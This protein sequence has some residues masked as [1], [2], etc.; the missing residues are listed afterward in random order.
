M[1]ITTWNILAQR[2]APNG[3]IQWKSRLETI[4]KVLI[5]LNSDII[6][7]Q[8]VELDCIHDLDNLLDYD[9]VGHVVSNQRTN[10]IGNITLWKREKLT[11]SQLFTNST[12]VLT[13]FTN[14]LCICNVHL[15]ARNL[16]RR[17]TQLKS[18]LKKQNYAAGVICGDFNDCLDESQSLALLLEEY[19]YDICHGKETYN[20]HA[21]DHACVKGM[22]CARVLTQYSRTS[23]SDHVPMSYRL[24]KYNDI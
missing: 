4:L 11:L 13:I 19:G 16:N 21:L 15:D 22:D 6:C 7:L 20:H 5:Q 3:T 23:A 9:K 8:E 24:R 12:S 14:N 17:I 1:L 2:Y 10:P 18:T